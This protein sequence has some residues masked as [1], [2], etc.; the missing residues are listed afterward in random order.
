MDTSPRK[1]PSIFAQPLPMDSN[2]ETL[3]KLDMNQPSDLSFAFEIGLQPEI[4]IAPLSSATINRKVVEVTE[5]MVNDEAARLQTRHGKMTE[6]ET[7]GSDENT[8]NVTFEETDENGNAVENGITKDNSLLVS[9]FSEAVSP[10]L[11]GL[12]I[13]DKIPVQLSEAFEEKEL[14]WIINDLGLKD[15]ETAGSKHFSIT[16]QK[17]GLVEKRDLDEPFFS[18]LYPDKAIATEAEFREA[19]KADI[20]A[21]WNNQARGQVHDEVYHYLIDN[22]QVDFPETF[23]KKWIQV[24]GEKQKT[25]EEA[26]AEFPSFKNSLKWTLISDKLIKE[27]NFDVTPEELKAFGRMQ[28]I[29]YMGGQIPN[30]DM[31]WLDGY[32]DKMMQDKK[33]VEQTYNQVITDKLFVWSEGQVAYK[34]VPMSVDEFEKTAHHHNH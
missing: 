29:S 1:T 13:G 32:L 23:L 5:E 12:K 11:I 10:K 20:Q 7:V 15:D 22:T 34:D 14:E 25:A 21:Y 19:L 27:N 9:Y 3:R 4:S 8:L 6:P 17:I 18:E 2:S 33:Y 26:E 24:G 28:M 31:G 30:G 16:I